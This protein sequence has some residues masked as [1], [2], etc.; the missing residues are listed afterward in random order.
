[1]AAILV[2]SENETSINVSYRRFV[3]LINLPIKKSILS[4]QF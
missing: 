3:K 1:M 2:L 4:V